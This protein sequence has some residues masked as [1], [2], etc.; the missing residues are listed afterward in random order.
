MNRFVFKSRHCEAFS[1]EAISPKRKIATLSLAM[2][3]AILLFATS[4]KK[5]S[6]SL[7]FKDL[8]YG[9]NPRNKIDIHLP[10]QR[11]T[12]TAM[13]LLI[14]GGGWVA[15]DKGDWSQEI[16]NEFLNSG[17]AVSSMNYRYANGDFHNQINDIQQA[18]DFMRTKSSSWKI[19][20]TKFA[21]IGASAGGHL[22]LLYAHAYDSLDVV[23]TVIPIVGPTDMTDPVFHQYAT[24]YGIFYVFEALLGS[25]MPN[26]P[27]VYEDA[28]PIFNY[29]NVP[30]FFICGGLD[31]LVPPQQSIRMFDTLTVHSIIADTTVFNNA[32]HDVFGPN[33]VNKQQIYDEVKG[34]LNTYLN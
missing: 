26:N 7:V 25:T 6:D 32:G 29:S 9:S 17:Y 20:S 15:G 10:Q 2:T 24:N 30:T 16:I 28:S 1:A 4:C 18:I 22:A 3:F 31:D 8:N 23:K 5:P 27:Q 34:W 33:Q 19:S 14:H 12:A 13:V 21:L 11:D